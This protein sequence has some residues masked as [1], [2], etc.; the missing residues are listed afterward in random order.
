MRIMIDTNIIISAALFPNGKVAKAYIKA[1]LPPYHP[2]VCDYIV[3]E[4]HRKFREK[5]PGRTTELE[6]FLFN[7]FLK[8]GDWPTAFVIC[9]AVLLCA[10]ACQIYL[11]FAGKKGADQSKSI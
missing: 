1:L 10:G 11:F 2:M 8:L 5:F 7:T 9:F 3:D 4:L 6:A